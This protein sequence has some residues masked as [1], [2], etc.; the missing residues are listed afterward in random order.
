MIIYHLMVKTHR[1]TGLKYLCQTARKNPH[2]YKGSGL[3]WKRHLKVHGADF[4]THIILKCY[5]KSAIREWGL[6]YSKLWSVVE[7]KQWA[8]MIPETGVG[9]DPETI[10]GFWKDPNSK[11]NRPEFREILSKRLKNAR[12]DPNSTYNSQQYKDNLKIIRKNIWKDTNTKFF[13]EEY[14]TRKSE[15]AKKKWADT[16]SHFQNNNKKFVATDPNG[17]VFEGKG[18]KKFCDENGL[19]QGH[20]A[21]VARGTKK[22]YKGWTCYYLSED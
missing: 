8:N 3:Y 2:K 16:N 9:T 17:K 5:T 11:F 6:Y 22:Q 7:S 4:D 19:N 1:I 13:S 14:R 12:R 20:M 15:T 18:L 10:S 21:S